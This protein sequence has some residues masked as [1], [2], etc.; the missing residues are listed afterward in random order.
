MKKFFKSFIYSGEDPQ[1]VY[2]YIGTLL[3]LV[4]AMMAMRLLQRGDF[5]DTL[6]LGVLG[7]VVTWAGVFNWNRNNA[8]KKED[9]K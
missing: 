8:V 5:S 4:I 7:L 3:M 9:D 6:I 1:P 2:V